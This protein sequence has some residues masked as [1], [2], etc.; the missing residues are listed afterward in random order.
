MILG[1][2]GYQSFR[3]LLRAAFAD[4]LQRFAFQGQLQQTQTCFYILF[5]ELYTLEYNYSLK[6][7]LEKSLFLSLH[8]QFQ[9]LTHSSV[10]AWRVPGMG[11]PGRLPSMGGCAESN[12]TEE[13]QQQQLLMFTAVIFNAQINPI[14]DHQEPHQ[15]VSQ[16]LWM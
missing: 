11:E 9:I 14:F 2:V 13:T 7:N 4:Y 10:L 16:V 3:S 8:W 5:L 12:M 15:T 6:R 1:T